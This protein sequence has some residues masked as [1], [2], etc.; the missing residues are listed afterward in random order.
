MYED[1]SQEGAA[2]LLNREAWYAALTHKIGSNTFKVAYAQAGDN[3]SG[4]NTGA[5]WYV[6]GVDHAL[7]KRTTVY[8]LHASTDNGGG[9]R[10]GLATGGS[11][12]AVVPAI[13]QDP[14]TF[15]IGVNHRF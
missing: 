1:L 2:T 11:S 14:S 12:G 6:V 7:S 4:A 8:A 15:S 10:Y 9:A 13:G 5:N 3:D